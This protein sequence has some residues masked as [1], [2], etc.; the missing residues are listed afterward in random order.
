MVEVAVE[1]ESRVEELESA[2]ELKLELDETE[3]EISEEDELS[4]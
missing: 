2:D 1:L 3:D 4:A